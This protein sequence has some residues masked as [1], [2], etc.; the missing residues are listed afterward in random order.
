[1]QPESILILADALREYFGDSELFELA[2]LFDVQLEV[3]GAR[4][5]HLRTARAVSERLEHGNNR[6]FVHAVADHALTRCQERI[7]HTAWE[8]RAYHQSML[9]R[10]EDL[11]AKLGKA[12]LPMEITVP[13]GH[14]FTAK[15]EAREF[16]GKSETEVLIVDPY[17][18]VGTLDCLRGVG[19]SVRI[20]TGDKPKSVEQGFAS[21]VAQ[22][23]SEG[24]TVEVRGHPKLHDRYLVF[25]GRSWLVGSSFKDAGKR[26]FSII[27][28]VDGRST[29]VAEIE[30]KWSQGA[31]IG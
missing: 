24:H 28:L 29:V 18:G 15:S 25:N 22:F 9:P 17:I 5:A 23:R 7:A 21:A 20:L 2:A 13:E 4:P 8:R 26:T 1:M 14:P 12:A 6:R 11:C 31:P 19:H 27:E 30:R 10:L 16:I 3:E